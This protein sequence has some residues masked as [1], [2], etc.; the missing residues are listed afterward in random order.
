MINS[1]LSYKE[2]INKKAEISLSVLFLLS[3]FLNQ[4]FG[5]SM[6][7]SDIFGSDWN[8][9]INFLEENNSWI[10]PALEK[11]GILYTEAVAVVFPELVRYSALRDK[12]E[13]SVLKALYCNLGNDYAD[14]S[15]GVFQVKPSFAERI[16]T[17]ARFNSRGRL[18]EKKASDTGTYA[19]RK[20]IVDDLENP[21]RELNYI[22]AFLKI[23]RKRFPLKWEDETRKIR[24]LAT[25]YNTG[26]WKTPEEIRA[27]EGK[28][29]FSTKLLKAETYSYADISVFWY[30]Q[31]LHNPG[32]IKK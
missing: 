15:I 4:S 32:E 21:Q 1:K 13:T 3:G 30:N 25:A 31:Y 26:F 7:Y 11:N 24:F 8:K 22:I 12:M 2:V 29:F 6:I 14:F 23:C 16:R 9:A 19:Y 5:Q 28:K 20:S 10:K 18:F 17:E 27:M